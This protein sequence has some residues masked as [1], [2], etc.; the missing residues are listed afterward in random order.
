MA[1]NAF[2]TPS[3]R[4]LCQLLPVQLVSFTARI[5]NVDV[6]LKWRTATEMNNFG[7]EVQRSN[8][9]SQSWTSV[10]FVP[11]N[12]TSNAPINYSF[13]DLNAKSAGSEL[14]Y[15]LK[16]I[17]RNGAEEY[18]GILVANFFETVAQPAILSVYPNPVSQTTTALRF[19]L[20]AATNV[21]LTV[22]DMLGREVLTLHKDE[23][24]ES[25][26]HTVSLDMNGLMP[27]TYVAILKTTGGAATYKI[28]VSR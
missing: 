26:E 4:L 28:T 16:Q 3:A 6:Q 24:M 14:L 18:S 19:G 11:G 1:L 27:G 25:G 2:L 8:D 15:R 13:T 9:G 12:G 23:A 10:G 20:P 7:F 17:D 21:S 22:Q 5:Q